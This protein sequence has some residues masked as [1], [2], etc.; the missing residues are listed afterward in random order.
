MMVVS[1]N[2]SAIEEIVSRF[3]YDQDVP[4]A[5]LKNDDLVRALV[6]V[7]GRSGYGPWC[8]PVL[9]G[10]SRQCFSSR[11]RARTVPWFSISRNRGAGVQM[12][13]PLEKEVLSVDWNILLAV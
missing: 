3:L 2:L 1:A 5:D 7:G 10:D 13:N 12:V 11:A 9:P 6:K 4:P 8:R